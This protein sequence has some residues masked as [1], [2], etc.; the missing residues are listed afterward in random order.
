[1][2][3]N[4]ESW[5]STADRGAMM[6]GIYEQEVLEALDSLSPGRWPVTAGVVE[7]LG[8]SL[9]QAKPLLRKI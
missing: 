5:W 1:M 3:L 7:L 4:R 8:K 6:L 9:A 2:S